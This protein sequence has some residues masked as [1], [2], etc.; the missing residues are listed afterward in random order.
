MKLHKKKKK[1]KT[2]C[3][4]NI[5]F[6][7][8]TLILSKRIKLPA[9]QV[10][11]VNHTDSK[12]RTFCNRSPVIQVKLMILFEGKRCFVTLA[13]SSGNENEGEGGWEERENISSEEEEKKKQNTSSLTECTFTGS[14]E[15]MLVVLNN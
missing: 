2:K 6:P 9:L 15:T 12:M 3:K 8:F 4:S 10:T 5:N 11:V 14:T 1:K 13:P 7:S